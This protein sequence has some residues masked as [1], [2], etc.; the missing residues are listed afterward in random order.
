V[1]N[2]ARPFVANDVVRLGPNN[3]SGLAAS[4]AVLL[5]TTGDWAQAASV[6]AVTA[7]KKN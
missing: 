4:D 7:M 1:A 5:V 3:A 6:T 2:E